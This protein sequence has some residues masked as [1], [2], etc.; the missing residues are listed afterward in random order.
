MAL[1]VL[2]PDRGRTRPERAE[3][4]AQASAAESAA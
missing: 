3:V 4:P 2:W 1:Y